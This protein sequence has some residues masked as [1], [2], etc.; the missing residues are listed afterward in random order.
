[1]FFQIV[2]I[3]NMEISQTQGDTTTKGNTG[4]ARPD[5]ELH[6]ENAMKDSIWANW[7]NRKTTSRLYKYYVNVTFTEVDYGWIGQGNI[8]N[9]E[10]IHREVFKDKGREVCN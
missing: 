9:S 1:M 6:G 3:I 4:N 5:P 7:L 2:N 8:S 10:E